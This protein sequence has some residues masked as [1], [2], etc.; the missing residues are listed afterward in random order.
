MMID[1][2]PS[3]A[4]KML[5]ILVVDDQPAFRQLA[6]TLLNGH[7]G[8]VVVGETD[9]GESALALI[10]KL[11][12][13]LVIMDVQLPGISGFEAAWQ[14]LESYP[15]VRVVMISAYDFQY[16]PLAKAVGAAG[17]LPKKNLSAEAIEA[18]VSQ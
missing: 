18:I 7:K 10:P 15:K 9:S 2:Q 6:R 8:Y 1:T 16:E 11:N 14:M 5:S 12:P 13:D 4:N 3:V 17:F